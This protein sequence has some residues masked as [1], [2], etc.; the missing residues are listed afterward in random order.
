MR[1]WIEIV[2]TASVEPIE[3]KLGKMGG[4]A[5]AALIGTA[6]AIPKKAN[7]YDEQNVAQVQAEINRQEDLKLLALT[8][9]GEARGDGPEAM[10]AVGHVIANRM[11]A[12]RFGDSVKDVVW[13][14]KAFSCWNPGDPNREAM[15]NIAQLP[16]ESVDRKRWQQAL[17]ISQEILS[18][19]S[20]DITNGALFYHTKQINPYWVEDNAE[21]TAIIANHVFYDTDKKA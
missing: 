10:R 14:R 13:K 12:E 11:E 7:P 15:S 4:L 6:G 19:R 5:A 2:E 18:G 16:K 9:W 20:R 8:I 21:P 1:D 3:E 17:Q